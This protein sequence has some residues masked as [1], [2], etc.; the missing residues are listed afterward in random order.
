MFAKDLSNKIFLPPRHQDTKFNDNKHL[1]FVSW[2]LCGYSFR[3]IRVGNNYEFEAFAKRFVKIFSSA[4]WFQTN[5]NGSAALG[6]AGL[7]LK[8]QSTG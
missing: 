7:I 6:P 5:G 4:S 3:F 2:C 1:F 8:I